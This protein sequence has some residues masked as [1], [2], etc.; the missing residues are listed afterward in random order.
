MY[1]AT[2]MPKL[3][4]HNYSVKTIQSQLIR[5]NFSVTTIQTQLFSHNYSVMT[6]QSNYSI[7]NYLVPPAHSPHVHSTSAKTQLINNLAG[8]ATL[9]FEPAWTCMERHG[10]VL[11]HK[12]T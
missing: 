3:F 11:V 7:F 2:N 12:K 1:C 8:S 6:I 5:H 9:M 10:N 4:S